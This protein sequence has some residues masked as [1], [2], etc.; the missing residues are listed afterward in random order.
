MKRKKRIGETNMGEDKQI[1]TDST[2]PGTKRERAEQARLLKAWRIS[3]MQIPL[4]KKGCFEASYPSKEWREIPSRKASPAPMLPRRGPRPLITDQIIG[5][6]KDVSAQACAGLIS[7]ATGSFDSVNGVTS[8]SGNGVI[9]AYT[10]QLNTNP[11]PLPPGLFPGAAAGCR[12]WEQFVFYNNGTPGNTAQVY[13]QYWLLGYGTTSPG[14][15]WTQSDP[16]NNTNWAI[17]AWANA[18][19]PIIA[20]GQ[21]AD[22]KPG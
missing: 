14:T 2:I 20:M 10:L 13:I 1:K 18:V 17:L 15:N 4:P 16:N 5:N 7:S 12:G 9:D 19:G 21:P 6:G 8:E 22:H 11:F 3:M